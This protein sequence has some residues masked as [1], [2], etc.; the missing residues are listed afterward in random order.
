MFHLGDC[1]FDGIVPS[2]GFEYRRKEVGCPPDVVQLLFDDRSVVKCLLSN[3]VLRGGDKSS[4]VIRVH[5]CTDSHG[6]GGNTYYICSV[7]LSITT[8]A[9][10]GSSVE[11]FSFNRSGT[12]TL[13]TNITVRPDEE[14]SPVKREVIFTSHSSY[15]ASP[16]FISPAF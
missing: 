9:N 12:G 5:L 6:G 7:D 8:L 4:D 14:A 1:I 11:T 16:V 13:H 3:R 10:L 2:S 15:G